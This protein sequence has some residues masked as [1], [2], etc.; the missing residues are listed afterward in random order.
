MSI[1]IVN[2]NFTNLILLFLKVNRQ[3]ILMRGADMI[4]KKDINR[5][6]SALLIPNYEFAFACKAARGVV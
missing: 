5:I 1:H 3:K 6:S 4:R 2:F